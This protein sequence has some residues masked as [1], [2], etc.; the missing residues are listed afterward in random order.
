VKRSPSTPNPAVV[1]KIIARDCIR[2]VRPRDRPLSTLMVRH[3]S[4]VAYEIVQRDGCLIYFLNMHPRSPIPPPTQRWL[5]S[6]LLFLSLS[7][8]NG[9][10]IADVAGFLARKEDEVREKAEELRRSA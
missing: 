3:N 8:E 7:L 9:M 4:R 10:P 5:K 6:D 2:E 1:G